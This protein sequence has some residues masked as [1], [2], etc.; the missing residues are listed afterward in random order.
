MKVGRQIIAITVL[1]MFGG[2]TVMAAE[3]E[4]SVTS[5][6]R[7]GGVALQMNRYADPEK[8]KEWN[9]V[10]E[11]LPG[12]EIPMLTEVENLGEDCFIRF[13]VRAKSDGQREIS[14]D[15]FGG[16]SEDWVQKGE[17]FYSTEI[18]ERGEKKELFT[19]F[20][21]PETWE[22]KDRETIQVFVTADAV[23]SRNF[24]PD[25]D[26][27]YPWGEVRIQKVSGKENG[28][29]LRTAVPQKGT[30]RVVVEGDGIIIVPDTFFSEFGTMV[31]GDTIQGELQ[32]DN[33]CAQTEA[34]YWKLDTGEEKL[35]DQAELQIEKQD[36]TVLYQGKLLEYPSG[37]YALLDRYPKD[38]KDRLTFTLH[39]PEEMDN[40]YRLL[41]AGLTWTFRAVSEEKEAEF[42]Q[43]VQRE[44][45]KTGDESH[46]IL[47][48][49]L[50]GAAMTAG[51]LVIRRRRHG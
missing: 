6:I 49:F 12:Q 43:E 7:S 42:L 24:T 32:I 37:Q 38:A 20:T 19:S 8:T 5:Q 10:G 17:Y 40:A 14:T 30:C 22:Q 13:Q 36:G 35:F 4:A 41:N 46:L 47:F 28:D 31:P 26:S 11:V 9:D 50:L 3:K 18:L 34:V 48:M 27:E 29:Q 1:W 51:I 45:V 16:I 15:C 23:Q 33:W 44:T 21:L 2:I 39:F 25:F